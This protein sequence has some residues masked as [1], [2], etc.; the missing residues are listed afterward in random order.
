IHVGALLV[1]A[2]VLPLRVSELAGPPSSEHPILWLL[3]VLMLSIGAPFAVL[4]ATA[5]LEQ[6]WYARVFREEGG[7]EPYVLYAAS[8]LGSLIALLA[9][10]AIFEP[11]TT[12]QGQRLGWSLG[13]LGFVI[14]M[15][16]LAWRV[17]R[18][19]FDAPRSEEHT[20]E[21]QSRENLVC[22]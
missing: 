9:Y 16:I 14:L 17:S 22:R 3:A 20:S 12:L 18:A 13:Y 7:P 8:N 4:S 5:P 2:L 6:A 11:T 21:L 19:A 1:A 10:P 15:G